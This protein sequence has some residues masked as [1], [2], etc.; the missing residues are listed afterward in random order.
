METLNIGI[1]MYAEKI[2]AMK[3]EPYFPVKRKSRSL[4][5]NLPG[6][7]G[8]TQPVQKMET[9]ITGIVNAVGK[10][11]MILITEKN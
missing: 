6:L 7:I 9:L 3:R 2:S 4:N 11:M 10:I 5:I 1:A 8:K